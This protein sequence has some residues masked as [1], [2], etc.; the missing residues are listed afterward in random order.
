MRADVTDHH[1]TVVVA[2]IEGGLVQW[3]VDPSVPL[4]ALSDPVMDVLLRGL[5]SSGGPHDGTAA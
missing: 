1:A 4:E 5:D 3:L 2:A